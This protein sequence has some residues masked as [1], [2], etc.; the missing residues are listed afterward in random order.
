MMKTF[1]LWKYCFMN[2]TCSGFVNWNHNCF[3]PSVSVIFFWLL[4]RNNLTKKKQKPKLCI[5]VAGVL[6]GYPLSTFSHNN[7][8]SENYFNLHFNS[9]TNT[10]KKNH[11]NMNH[12]PKWVLGSSE[13]F[14]WVLKMKDKNIPTNKNGHSQIWCLWHTHKL[15]W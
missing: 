13:S 10:K 14:Y 9:R 4:T 5:Q 15:T 11:S 8:P 1:E 12:K 6:F 2:N 7:G 3:F